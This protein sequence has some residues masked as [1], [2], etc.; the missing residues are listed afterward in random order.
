MQ[1][2]IL[3]PIGE[4]ISSVDDIYEMPLGGKNAQIKIYPQYQDALLRIET[5]S[6]LWV[7]SWFHKSSRQKLQA[8]PHKVN[9]ELPSYGVFA[10]RAFD[11]PNPIGLSL[12]RLEKV[13]GN[14]LHVRGLDAISGTPVVDIKPYFED[15]IIFSPRTPYI[16]G[17]N[18]EMRRDLL[19]RQA[20]SH[21]QEEC[22]DLH[23]AVRM[24][25]VAEE[26]LGKIHNPE[27]VLNISGSLCL[28]D[29]LQGVSRARLSNPPR[30]TFSESNS[31]R[32]EWI[33]NNEKLTVTLKNQDLKISDIKDKSDEELFE[34]DYKQ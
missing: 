18:L 7:L 30:F 27:V 16:K 8:N 33:K 14:I 2:I 13:E 31:Y 3:N 26:Y 23:I 24:A 29:C 11:R 20:F 34:I 10:L 12:V 4:V 19:Y 6:H 5:N 25:S 28:G 15:D 9:P 21:H 17:G 32:S 1:D 22:L